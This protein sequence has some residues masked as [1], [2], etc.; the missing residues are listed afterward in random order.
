MDDRS[1]DR[2]APLLAGT[3]QV[4]T[5]TGPGHGQ[6]HCASGDPDRGYSTE[7]CAAAAA[8]VLTELGVRDPVD[9]VGNTWG[10]LLASRRNRPQPGA[11]R[12]VWFPALASVALSD[13]DTPT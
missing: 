7:E 2:L 6:G 13:P 9:W 8:T 4:I 5:V 12:P 11:R 3:R 10:R 1:W